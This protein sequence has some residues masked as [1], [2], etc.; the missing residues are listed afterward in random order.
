VPSGVGRF[1]KGDLELAAEIRRLVDERPTYGYRRIIA[2]LRR[3][4]RLM[5]K[6][7]LLLARHTGRRRQ[8]AHDGKVVSL[9]SNTRP[10]RSA[11]RRPSGIGSIA[12]CDRWTATTTGISGEIVR[13]LMIACVEQR[14]QDTSPNPVAVR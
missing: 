6:H 7:G 4:C 10:R 5:K 8:Q 12:S 2:L 3:I 11:D 1:G 9:R 14:C 13:D